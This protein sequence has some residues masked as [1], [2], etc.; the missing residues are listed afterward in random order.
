MSPSCF[1]SHTHDCFQTQ[2]SFSKSSAAL[3]AKTNRFVLFSNCHVNEPEDW[4]LLSLIV[5]ISLSTLL[6]GWVFLSST[7]PAFRHV[8]V[9]HTIEEQITPK[10]FHF[11][12]QILQEVLLGLSDRSPISIVQHW[13]FGLPSVV[14]ATMGINSS[15][16][17]L[18]TR[19]PIGAIDSHRLTNK[20]EP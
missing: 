7:R 3:L 10:S 15:F 8:R 4:T 12:H 14:R 5:H 16:V 13:L 9:P 6:V 1:S 2:R 19:L 20:H 17:F 11:A 18:G